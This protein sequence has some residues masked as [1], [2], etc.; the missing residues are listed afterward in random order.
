MRQPSNIIPIE[1]MKY[2]IEDAIRG[3]R[4]I[5]I[6]EIA[7]CGLFKIATDIAM[8]FFDFN[9]VC[10]VEGCQDLMG[11]TSNKVG[12]VKFWADLFHD[13]VVEY[14]ETKPFKQEPVCMKV[15][16]DCSF[17]HTKLMFIIEAHLIPRDALRMIEEEFVGLIIELVD[18]YDV[19]GED[20]TN[21][22]TIVQSWYKLS[23]T[24]SYARSL[25]GIDTPYC[26][27]KLKSIISQKKLSKRSVGKI[28]TNQYIS[29]NAEYVNEIRVKQLQQ[30][31]RKNQKIICCDNRINLIMDNTGK[32]LSFTKN[33]IGIFTNVPRIFV[34]TVRIHSTKFMYY[35]RFNYEKNG[36]EI[37]VQPANIISTLEAS[38][39]RF[40]SSV[41]VMDSSITKRELYS[42]MKNSNNVILSSM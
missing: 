7:G 42:I 19:G 28:D 17:M 9:E 39:H 13:E 36:T 40:Q 2:Y 12:N 18:P 25:Y 23:L 24:T 22:P 1:D 31:F 34:P 21:V 4:R 15:I 30:A 35:G 16:D 26:D 37:L 32:R 29:N 38:H 8:S 6:G 33:A 27:K 41:L 5:V 20:Y 3:G 10:F 14:V 11:Y